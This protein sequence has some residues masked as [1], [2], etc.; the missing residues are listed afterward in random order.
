MAHVPPPVSVA[1]HLRCM[2]VDVPHL[3]CQLPLEWILASEDIGSYIVAPWSNEK[4]IEF[5]ALHDKGRLCG[6]TE[7]SDCGVG[8]SDMSVTPFDQILARPVRHNVISTGW[9]AV[10]CVVHDPSAP[11]SQNKRIPG[12]ITVNDHRI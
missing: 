12:V 6:T 2:R 11:D 5:A 9:F 10:C 7:S 3:L 8:K 1:H 4:V